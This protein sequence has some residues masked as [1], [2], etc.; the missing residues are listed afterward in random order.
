LIHS[1]L[2]INLCGKE[3]REKGRK[4]EGSREM[5]RDM[6]RKKKDKVDKL[7]C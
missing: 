2:S 4:E 6:G 3:W 7:I 1:K 5:L